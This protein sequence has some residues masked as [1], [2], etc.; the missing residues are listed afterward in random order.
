MPSVPSSESDLRCRFCRCQTWAN[1]EGLRLRWN[2][3][4]RSVFAVRFPDTLATNDFDHDPPCQDVPSCCSRATRVTR[5]SGWWTGVTQKAWPPEASSSHC[6]RLYGNIPADRGLLAHHGVGSGSERKGETRCRRLLGERKTQTS[7]GPPL[8][9]LETSCPGMLA[10]LSFFLSLSL[11][12]NIY[13]YIHTDWHSWIQTI[14]KLSENHPWIEVFRKTLSL[15][16]PILFG[17]SG[18]GGHSGGH[19]PTRHDN[20][21]DLQP[22][23][24]KFEGQSIQ[25]SQHISDPQTHTHSVTHARHSMLSTTSGF[26][27]FEAAS[28]STSPIS[29]AAAA[30]GTGA[31]FVWLQPPR[32][33]CAVLNWGFFRSDPGSFGGWRLKSFRSIY[34]E[35]HFG[36]R[37]T[38]LIC[39]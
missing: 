31:L 4:T 25:S 26:V 22:G 24:M 3:Q 8:T 19:A 30:E 18:R 14:R 17:C 34:R 27:S 37:K 2:I 1:H 15:G 11:Y 16:T 36:T 29:K 33:R 32:R 9:C 6:A 20:S 5:M 35:S 13:I 28:T 38:P 21:C 7:S 39:H 12:T 10:A 23:N